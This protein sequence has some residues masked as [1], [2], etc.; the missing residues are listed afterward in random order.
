MC[1]PCSSVADAIAPAAESTSKRAALPFVSCLCSATRVSLLALAMPHSAPR[2]RCLLAL[3]SRQLAAQVNDLPYMMIRMPRTTH[4]NLETIRGFR[5]P[6]G[7]I[8]LSPVCRALLSN[9]RRHHR[10]RAV[11]RSQRFVLPRWLPVRK[12]PVAVAH[13]SRLGNASSDVIVQITG[14]V[15][16]QV[17]NAVSIR[18][19]LA[20]ELFVRK[21][22]RPLV[23]LRRN[24]FVIGCQPRNH[25]F[26]HFRHEGRPLCTHPATY[27][28]NSRAAGL[29]PPSATLHSGH[30]SY[31]TF[32]RRFQSNPGTPTIASPSK[33]SSNSLSS[34]SFRRLRR[35][36]IE[37]FLVRFFSVLRG[38]SHFFHNP[39]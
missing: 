30:S 13:V 15:Q 18:I 35:H 11:K 4:E 25:C 8:R 39:R 36:G 23:Q 24:I 12:L 32:F 27:L 10:H 16:H 34:A 37:F 38:P 17:S 9:R 26:V 1:Q 22:L 6:F 3:S 20:P 19:R 29:I 7:R 14:H 5:L 2:R 33:M 28:R 31:R 21:R